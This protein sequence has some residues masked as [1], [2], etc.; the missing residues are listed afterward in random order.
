MITVRCNSSR[1]FFILLL[2]S[3]PARAD[4]ARNG[5]VAP[6]LQKVVEEYC[7][8]VSDAAAERRMAQ[9]AS[10]LQDLRARVEDRIT[11]LEQAKAELES[12]IKRQEALRTLA[13]Q[14]LVAMYSGMDPE[15]AGAQME[16]LGPALASS[17]LRQLK[18]RQASAILNEMKPEL[19]AQLVKII[20]SASQTGRDQK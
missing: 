4:S 11:R 5:G 19:A 12:V 3:A 6:D 13:D 7:V 10:S 17:V 15:T 2:I 18:P 9:Q 1:A 14:E 20:A 16:K 8:A